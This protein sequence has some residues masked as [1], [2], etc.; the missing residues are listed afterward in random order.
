MVWTLIMSR[1]VHVVGLLLFGGIL[2]AG[3]VGV[4]HAKFWFSL[5]SEYLRYGYVLPEGA[6]RRTAI[7][8]GENISFLFIPITD[9]MAWG[10]AN[11]PSQPKSV[12][13]WREALGA[14][15]VLNG[16]YFT[17]TNA[18]AGYYSLDGE[19]NMPCPMA[20]NHGD[21]VSGY[22]F[23]VWIES[24]RL[25]F[26]YAAD[27][28]DICGGPGVPPVTAFAS[29]PTLVYQDTSMIE[30]DSE[31]K[32]HRTMLAKTTDGKSMIVMTESGELTL[33]D[34]AQWFLEH[35][36]EYEVVGNLDGG[37]STGLSMT[38]ARWSVEIPSAAVPNV[39][40]GR[41]E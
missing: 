20:S 29:F 15:I 17:E 1:P 12:H 34:A 25:D 37:P 41:R 19:A 11:D 24:G 5:A 39:I 2:A 40:L 30:K 28:P 16:A 33:H 3:F 18:P 32:A 14:N 38:G 10:F 4:Y 27:H 22:T 13:E 31:L 9:D 21:V 36:E 6:E 35:S 8:D 26:G 7:I 23:A